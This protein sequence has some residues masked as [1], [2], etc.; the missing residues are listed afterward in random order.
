MDPSKLH[1]VSNLVYDIRCISHVIM[2]FRPLCPLV[3]HNGFNLRLR[4]DTLV[5][6]GHNGIGGED[7]FAN[8]NSCIS[9]FVSKFNRRNHLKVK[10]N[11]ANDTMRYQI[12]LI[13]S[14]IDRLHIGLC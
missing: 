12:V 5:A 10:I 2:C 13:F 1:S 9:K 3:S 6:G 7:I 4:E 14:Y 11:I 8:A